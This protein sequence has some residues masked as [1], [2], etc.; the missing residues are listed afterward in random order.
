MSLS[1][2]NHWL[3]LRATAIA[4]I[5]LCV[6]LVY[7]IVDLAGADYV[8]FTTWLQQPLNAILLIA[9][10]AVSFYHASLGVHEILEDYVHN[11]NLLCASMIA[12]KAFFILVGALCIY[13]IVKVAF[14]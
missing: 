5:P 6:W 7:S 2:K 3:V 8:T 14:L 12:K 9:F 13:S 11:K 4:A 10:I 1:A